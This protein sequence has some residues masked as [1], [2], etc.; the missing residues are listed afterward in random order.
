MLRVFEYDRNLW[1]STV[2]HDQPRLIDHIKAASLSTMAAVAAAGRER[3]DD[4]DRTARIIV[5]RWRWRKAA[6]EHGQRQA[7][8]QA[9]MQ[10]F[11]ASSFAA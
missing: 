4:A 5:L 9:V 11:S 3:H 6:E 2:D 1:S 10:R 7:W 8:D